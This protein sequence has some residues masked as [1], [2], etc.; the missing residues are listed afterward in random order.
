ME[1]LSKIL[2]LAWHVQADLPCADFL[3]PEGQRGKIIAE[4]VF[5]TQVV[6]EKL[7]PFFN[8]FVAKT[9]KLCNDVESNPGPAGS[10]RKPR[11]SLNTGLFENLMGQYVMEFWSFLWFAYLGSM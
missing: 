7:L 5:S 8:P 2:I 3:C 4:V 6:I 1:A 11:Y 10:P 9:L